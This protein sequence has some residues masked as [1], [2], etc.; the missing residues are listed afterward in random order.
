M[1]QLAN[2]IPVEAI[3]M[4]ASQLM[5]ADNR[6]LLAMFPDK[7]GV[8]VPTEQQFAEVLAAVDAENIEGYVDNVINEPLIAQL[9]PRVRLSRQISIRYMVLLS[10]L[11]LMERV[12]WPGLP[13][14]RPGRFYLPHVLWEV[15]RHFPTVSIMSCA[16]WMSRFAAWH[17]AV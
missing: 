7:D 2:Q 11:F 13:I 9:P 5:P 8:V 1:S 6:V 4:T 17:G 14:S 3:N 10:G 16:I 12:S 15:H